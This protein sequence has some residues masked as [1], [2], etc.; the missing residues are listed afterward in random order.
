MIDRQF[1]AAFAKLYVLW[2]SSKGEVYGL[3]IIE[4]LRELGFKIS[5][6]T[7]YPTLHALLEEKD[8]TL[9]ARRVNGKLRKCYRATAKGQ[10]E[11]KEVVERLSR[12]LRKM[13]R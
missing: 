10:K 7:L 11:A 4:E 6:G 12:L 3:Q 5:P 1:Q 2:K 9:T 8:V 13:S